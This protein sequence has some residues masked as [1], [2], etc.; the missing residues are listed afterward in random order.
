MECKGVGSIEGFE[1][2][3]HRELISSI[4]SGNVDCLIEWIDGKKSRL[5]K[6]A[7]AYLRNHADVED[8]FHNTIIKVIDN[9]GKLKSEE[10]FESWF[11]SILMN[12]CRKILRDR[13]KVLPSEEIE[14]RGIYRNPGEEDNRIDIVNGIKNIDGE[15]KEMIILK[16]YSGY[17]QR[18]IS[19]I[20]HIP[21]G[22]VK[23]KIFRGLKALKAVLG[24]EE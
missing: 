15:Y 10:A 19:E 5:Y 12:E 9:A 23:T 20:L 11:I 3:K 17:T 4:K 1:K 16:Y 22:T 7:W 2:N 13:K 6:I 8:V 24:R 18:E 14:F 21:L